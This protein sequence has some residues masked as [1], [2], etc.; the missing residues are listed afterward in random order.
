MLSC[1]VN[2]QPASTLSVQD[3]GLAYGQGLFETLTLI[4]GKP[5]G[6][7]LHMQRLAL[8]AERLGIPFD[9]SLSDALS[10]DLVKLLAATESL[11]ERTVLKM[12]LTR[13]AGGRGYAVTEP[14]TPNR[15]LQ[16]NPFPVWPADPQTN[17]IR[18]MLCETRLGLN[19]QLAGIKHLN[20]LEQVLA[21]SEWQQPDI[22]EGLVCD[23]EGYLVEG[24]MSNLFW[25]RNGEL[26]TPD[27]TYCGIDG[28][29]RQRL[30]ERARE[31]QIKVNIGRYQPADLLDA[32]EVFLT[33]SVIGIWPVTECVST[34]L[35]QRWQI[36]TLSRQL[37][38]WLAEEQ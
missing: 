7:Q 12:I 34:G 36:G 2:G 15:I 6:W 11:P 30:I 8:G 1:I 14:L 17:G 5:Q 10:D 23:M 18:V 4:E 24:T 29:I 21:R 3:R 31:L 38:Q 32:D 22:S 37:N 25:T 27:L 16:L 26:F 9:N 28:I 13:G 20:R 35:Q 19:P 33:N